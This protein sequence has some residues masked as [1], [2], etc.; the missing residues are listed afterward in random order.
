LHIVQEVVAAHGGQITV[1]SVVGQGTTFTI[2]LPRVLPK[3]PTSSSG[4]R[5]SVA[6][7]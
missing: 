2:T 6:S 7:P 3:T 4:E 1:E 5:S